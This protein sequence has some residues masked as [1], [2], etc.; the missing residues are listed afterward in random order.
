MRQAFS[1]SAS[2]RT[3]NRW[4]AY[5]LLLLGVIFLIVAWLDLLNAYP[6]GELF[7]NSKW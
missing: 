5:V 4:Q 6:I 2:S 3:N 1:V 7:F